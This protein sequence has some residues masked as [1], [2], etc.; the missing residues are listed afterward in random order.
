MKLLLIIWMAIDPP[1]DILAE[2]ESSLIES[3]RSRNGLV[4]MVPS[5]HHLLLLL[6]SNHLS[7]LGN[8][9]YFPGFFLQ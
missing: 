9:R 1:T 5:H 8:C 4:D 6:F 3:C 7:K 2:T